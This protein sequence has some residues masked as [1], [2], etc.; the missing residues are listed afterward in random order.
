MIFFMVFLLVLSVFNYFL[1]STIRSNI[2]N[3]YEQGVAIEVESIALSLGEDPTEIPLTKID[4]P[5]QVW[6]N[7][8]TGSQKTYERIDFPKDLSEFFLLI[9]DEGYA[10]T[11]SAPTIIEIDDYTLGIATKEVLRQT[12]GTISLVLAKSNLGVY[13][14]IKTIGQWMIAANLGAA[15]ISL[16]LA[17]FVSRFT[18]RPIQALIDKAKSIKAS[19]EME[20]LPVS[21]ANDELTELSNT[22]NLMIERI[23]TSIKTQNQFFTSAAHELRTPL[24]NMLAELELRLSQHRASGDKALLESQKEEVIRL[25]YV[26]QDFLLM[27]QLKSDTLSLHIKPFRLDDLLYDVLEKMGHSIKTSA[28]E[29]NIFID[30]QTDRLTI[31]GDKIKMESILVNLIQNALKYGDAEE[32]IKIKV[33]VLSNSL[34]TSIGNKV[35]LQKQIQS[36]NKLGLWICGQLAEKQGFTFTW[37]SSADRFNAQLEIAINAHN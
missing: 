33:E 27:S 10:N 29:V 26:V 36:G 16:V 19:E 21:P 2:I 11:S 35:D 30:I 28:F 6:F 18:L 7:S 15:I 32:P 34:I 22:I 31:N 23:E 14:Q 8:L 12:S 4:Q 5:I 17:L 24:A 1:F 20:R 9:Q 37:S 25:K 13:A 3:T